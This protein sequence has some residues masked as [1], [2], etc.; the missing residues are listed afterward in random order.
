MLAIRIAVSTN[1]FPTS[2]RTRK[3]HAQ[4]GFDDCVVQ[5]I[6]AGNFF[7]LTIAI[8]TGLVDK[9][10]ISKRMIID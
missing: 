2:G 1:G 3:N 4:Q 6:H 10:T 7:F 8:S 5:K 9:T